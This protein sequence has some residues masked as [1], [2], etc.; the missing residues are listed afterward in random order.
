[1]LGITYRALRVVLLALVVTF[2]PHAFAA[3]DSAATDKTLSPYFFIENADPKLD[4]LPLQ[5]TKVNVTISGVIAEVN[6]T[7]VYKNDG[8][9]P[10]NARYVFP[11]STRAAVNGMRMTIRDQVIEA[12]IKEKKQA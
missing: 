10:I 8:K 12:Q 2:T 3:N 11:A 7:Q 6:V 1:M 5:A 4:Q 9:R